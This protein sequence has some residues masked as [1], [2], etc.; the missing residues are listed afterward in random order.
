MALGAKYHSKGLN[1]LAFPCNQFG[2]Q[3]PGDNRSIKA[4]VHHRFPRP[5]E[6]L[7][8]GLKL[9]SKVNVNGKKAHRI[10]R[11]LKSKKPGRISWNFGSY[12]LVSPNGEV[13][14]FNDIDVSP[15]GALHAYLES[16]I[17][18]SLGTTHTHGDRSEL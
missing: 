12:F 2:S 5:N 1:I 17:K 7:N 6:G 8:E 14:R 10:Y 3:E 9:M 15:Y 4:F 16:H 13:S 18:Q 11:F